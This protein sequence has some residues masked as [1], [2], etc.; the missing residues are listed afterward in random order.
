MPLS[1]YP[2]RDHHLVAN[3]YTTPI[4]TGVWEPQMP[5]ANQEEEIIQPS[6]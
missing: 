2:G 3:N 1:M 6:E 5:E 4:G